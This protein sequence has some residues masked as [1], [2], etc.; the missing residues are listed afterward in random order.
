MLQRPN[1]THH[2]PL[3]RHNLFPPPPKPLAIPVPGQ[4]AF[5]R[6]ERL[7]AA[8]L[9]SPLIGAPGHKYD[10]R[11]P[12]Y[13]DLSVEGTSGAAKNRQERRRR[14]V[15][16]QERPVEGEEG[17][18]GLMGSGEGGGGG[19]RKGDGLGLERRGESLALGEGEGGVGA[20]GQRNW[21]KRRRSGWAVEDE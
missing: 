18:F 5:R 13:G 17:V 2:T 12:L 6:N 7:L 10:M 8:G 14:F 19:A 11:T 4:M 9:P 16:G 1:A 21:T 15:P 3:N 20:G